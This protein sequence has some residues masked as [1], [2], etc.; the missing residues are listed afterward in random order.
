MRRAVLSAFGDDNAAI[1]DNVSALGAAP[2]RAD[3][4]AAVQCGR[5]AAGGFDRTAADDHAVAG[6][7]VSAADAGASSVA[8]G[9]DFSAGNVYIP[10]LGGRNRRVIGAAADSRAVVSALRHDRSAGNPD[11]AARPSMA[12]AAADA[13]ARQAALGD[14]GPPVDRDVAKRNV[15]AGVIGLA[16]AAADAGRAFASIRFDEAVVDHNGAAVDVVAAADAGRASAAGHLDR[17]RPPD[18]QRR[19]QRNID[20]GIVLA[21][22]IDD[23]VPHEGYRRVAEAR[24]TR[25]L[26]AVA[27]CARGVDRRV[28]QGHP[29]PGGYRYLPVAAEDALRDVAVGKRLATAQGREVDRGRPRARHKANRR[30]KRRKQSFH[31]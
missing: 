27:G 1:D 31:G 13:G 23:V 15:A 9:V 10:V 25:E 18:G 29:R 2:S 7:V 21:E 8:G 28:G 4:G 20:A 3:A 6:G 26:I 5:R 11:R 30:H 22:P 24:Q 14:Y 16:V 12:L 17:A 19:A